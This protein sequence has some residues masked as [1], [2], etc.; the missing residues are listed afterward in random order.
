[1]NKLIKKEPSLEFVIPVLKWLKDPESVSQKERCANYKATRLAA[2]ADY[3]SDTA[4][5]AA[6]AAAIAARA[7]DAVDTEEWINEY[8][9]RISPT[10]EEVESELF[11]GEEVEP[12][13]EV[14]LHWFNFHFTS[15]S[16]ASSTV[17]GY[18]T[19]LITIARIEE[20]KGFAD[21]PPHCALVSASYLG[22]ATAKVMGNE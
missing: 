14:S 17:T 11:K 20:N 4:A 2:D 22:Y 18:D 1:M 8:F 21:M 7:A 6:Y 3:A 12:V 5:Y 19:K 9:T 13:E 10:R 16:K 15:G